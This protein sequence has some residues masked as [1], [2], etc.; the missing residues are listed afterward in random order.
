MQQ[1][2]SPLMSFGA[3][4]RRSRQSVFSLQHL[5]HSIVVHASSLWLLLCTCAFAATPAP[6]VHLRFFASRGISGEVS[7]ICAMLTLVLQS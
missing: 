3:C 6:V 4:C 7:S 1:I 2:F 5:L